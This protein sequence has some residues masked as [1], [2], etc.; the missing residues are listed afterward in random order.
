MA[1]TVK[2]LRKRIGCSSGQSLLEFA[3]VVPMV[4]AVA[5]GVIELGYALLDQHVITK[6]AREGSNLISRNT[7]L[8]DAAAALRDMSTRPVDFTNGN[9]KMILS[10]IKKGATSG[11]SNYNQDILYQRYEYGTLAATSALTTRGGGSFG[12]APEYTAANSDSNTNLQI[13]NLPTG[14]VAANGYVYVT[15]IFTTH[16]LITPFGRLGIQVPRV[17]Y[18]IAYF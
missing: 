3:I 12:A 16:T 15:E 14:L 8:G 1:M 4:L 2:S 9:S 11:T 18:S 7:S 10:V 5:L 6:L 17:L 13:T